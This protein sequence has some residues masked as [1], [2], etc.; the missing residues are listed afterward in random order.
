MEHPNKEQRVNQAEL[1]AK[2]PEEM[3]EE[4]ARIFRLGNAAYIYH[5]QAD[6]LEPTEEDFKEWLEGLPNTIRRDMEMKGF[7][8]CKGILSFTRYVN[9][10]NDVGMG[11]WM[12]RNLNEEDYKAWAALR[13]ED[14]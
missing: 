8:L 7:E 13:N 3:R 5:R 4:H 2:L 14:E 9:E 10:K 1:L 11:E 12:K 6:E